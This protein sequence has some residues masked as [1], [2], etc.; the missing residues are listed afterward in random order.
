MKFTNFCLSQVCFFVC[1]SVPKDKQE[2]EGHVV[3][4]AGVVN[5]QLV[6]LLPVGILNYVTFKIFIF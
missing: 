3:L 6:C 1:I 4:G 2:V 5:S